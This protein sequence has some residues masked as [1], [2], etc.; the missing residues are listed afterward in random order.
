MNKLIST[1]RRYIDDAKTAGLAA[2]AGNDLTNALTLLRA[3]ELAYSPTGQR[4][5]ELN[6]LRRTARSIQ[7]QLNA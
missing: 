2:K 6:D 1:A 5:D 3:A 7:Q 4:R